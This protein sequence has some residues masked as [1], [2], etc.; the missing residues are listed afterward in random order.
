MKQI[1]DIPQDQESE[2]AISDEFVSPLG[3]ALDRQLRQ[4]SAINS[5]HIPRD[6]RTDN[7]NFPAVLVPV[8]ENVHHIIINS[9][10]VISSLSSTV[11]EILYKICNRPNAPITEIA[12]MLL[13]LI[14]K[15]GQELLGVY[16]LFEVTQDMSSL[17]PV[18]AQPEFEQL[19]GVI[20]VLSYLTAKN[21]EF[22]EIVKENNFV[23]HGLNFLNAACDIERGDASQHDWL[24]PLFAILD[25]L[26]RQGD[27]GS[28]YMIEIIS[29]FLK[30][31]HERKAK[32]G[33]TE[34]YSLLT[35]LNSLTV[36]PDFSKAFVESESV[37]PL[38]TL[39]VTSS[40]PKVRGLFTTYFNLLKQLAEDPYI[41]Q[42][43]FEIAIK[44]SLIGNPALDVFMKNFK[45]QIYRSKEIFKKAFENVCTC[46]KKDEKVYVEERKEREEIIAPRWDVVATIANALT[47]VYAIEQTG[48]SDFL[49]Q[50]EQLVSI[51]ADLVQ[52]YPLL[53]SNLLSLNIKGA[54]VTNNPKHSR[55]FLTHL[56]RNFIPFRYALS[57]TDKQITF[58]MPGTT[59]SVSP[60][61]YQN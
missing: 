45:A 20:Q 11:G 61:E 31:T 57:I 56:V 32:M 22:L 46:I 16:S 42:S 17:Q 36:N 12:I 33:Q 50:T 52:T 51:L 24:G 15:L 29:K 58:N 30:S 54:K 38:L 55:R 9:L 49:L 4:S 8:I 35:L 28:L 53:I 25:T 1:I 2:S 44:S 18:E 48:K 59:Q 41:L 5:L 60:D 37:F 21:S 43:L 23:E 6:Q 3:E 47:E 27:S 10:P 40:E 7:H 26:V 13:S 14:G 19:A 34:V 39:Q